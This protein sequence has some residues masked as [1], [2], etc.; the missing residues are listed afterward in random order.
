MI[1]KAKNNMPKILFKKSKNKEEILRFTAVSALV[2]LAFTVYNGA[3]GIIY[4]T[5][6]NISICVY[7]FLLFA[8][9]TMIFCCKP[10]EIK[11]EKRL[12]IVTHIMLILMDISLALP[13]YLMVMN[14][15][16]YTLGLIPAIAA[17]AY[18]T[19][20]ITLSIIHYVKT[21]KSRAHFLAELRAINMTD[22]LVSLLS[23]QNTMILANGGMNES[24]YIL[25]V[26]SSF[27]IF[28][29]II[30]ITVKSFLKIKNIQ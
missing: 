28:I 22:S 20:R 8:V 1:T 21:R 9:K 10:K 23:L 4:G 11:S 27:V 12:Y 7:Y 6:W 16:K 19:Y 18:T 17:A 14:K 24:M 15:R 2:S 13:A 30:A 26:C 29:I 25:S 3:I 5:V